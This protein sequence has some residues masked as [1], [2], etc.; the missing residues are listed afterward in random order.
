MLNGIT[1]SR[2]SALARH[3]VKPRLPITIDVL[4]RIFGVLASLQISDWLVTLLWA[5][6]SVCFFSFFRLSELLASS[7]NSLSS[8]KHLVWEDVLVDRIYNPSQL[9]VHLSTSKCDQFGKGVDI[10]IGRSQNH[11]CPVT[12]CLAYMAVHVWGPNPGP[13]FCTSDSLPFTKPQLVSEV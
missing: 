10:F 13:F 4:K 11:L 12:A 6:C 9:R 8:S 5:I 2:I 3:Q 1:G 7:A